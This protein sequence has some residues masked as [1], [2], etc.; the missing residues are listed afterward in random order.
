MELV[1]CVINTAVS[2]THTDC[3]AE[4]SGSGCRSS[5]SNFFESCHL[6]LSL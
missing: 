2:N 5:L 1:V 6:Q 3:E 4:A